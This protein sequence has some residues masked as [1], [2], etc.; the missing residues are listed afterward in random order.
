MMQLMILSSNRAVFLLEYTLCA[1]V[2]FSSL[3]SVCY[4][5]DSE[6]FSLNPFLKSQLPPV[7]SARSVSPWCARCFP[8]SSPTPIDREDRG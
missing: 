2:K 4:L 8:V 3:E 7:E 1:F 6:P 5:P